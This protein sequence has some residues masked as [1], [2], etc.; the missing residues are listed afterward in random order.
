MKTSLYSRRNVLKG[1]AASTLAAPLVIPSRA[2]GA[3][4][5][6]P[7]NE[8][9]VVGHIGVGGRGRQELR[10]FMQCQGAA[11][12]AVAD[13]FKSHREA[14]ARMCRGKAYADFRDILARDDIDAVAVTTPDHWHVPI[15]MAAARAGKAAFVAKPL[16][17]SI[18]QDLACRDLFNQLGHVFQY[19]TQQRSMAHCYLGCELVRAG[20]IGRVHTIEVLAPDGGTG[21]STQEAPVP[22]GLDYDM[23]LGPAPRRPYTVDRCKPPGSY[24]IY[25]YSIG[26]LAGWGAHPLDILVWASDADLS[27]PV[28]VEGTGTIPKQGLY[29]T[30]FHWDMKLRLGEVKMTFKPGRDLTRFIGDEGW[31]A[32]SRGGL[33]AEP[34]SLL[35]ETIAPEQARLVQ[36]AHHAGNFVEAV[37]EGKPVA[38]PVDQAARSDILSHLCNIA[39]RTGRKITWDP[40]TETILD[41]AE[42]ARMMRRPMRKPW[43]LGEEG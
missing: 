23:W 36:S 32:I 19:G 35:K 6:P 22:E 14:A 38:S 34:K 5:A 3:D 25:D 33:D 29:D 18:E 31:I 10:L 41:D 26:Y 43:T 20:R 2:L 30:V 24:W 16:G 13:P 12:V 9:V 8:R 4:G 40:K 11:N 39:V 27:G 21:G 17:L 7:A 28:I 1:L 37:R 15:A 42:A